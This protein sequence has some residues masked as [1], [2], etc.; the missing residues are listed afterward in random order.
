MNIIH[1]RPTVVALTCALACQL[2]AAQT[3]PGST[4]AAAMQTITI[5]ATRTRTLASD[6][7]ASISVTGG[8]QLDKQ[9]GISSESF[10]ALVKFVPRLETNSVPVNCQADRDIYFTTRAEGTRMTLS[11][12]ARF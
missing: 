6:V 4:E 9:V 1:S 2:A 12:S 3:G 11:Y 7:P 10:D 5:S 8:E